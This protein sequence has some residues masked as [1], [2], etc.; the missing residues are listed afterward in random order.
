MEIREKEAMGKTKVSGIEEFKKKYFYLNLY[1]F[2]SLTSTESSICFL[3]L[4]AL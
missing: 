4:L 2:T 3:S 1:S